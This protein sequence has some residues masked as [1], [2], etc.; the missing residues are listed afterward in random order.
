MWSAY[1]KKVLLVTGG[2]GFLGTTLLYRSLTEASP[3]QVYVLCR[4]GRKR[5]LERWLEHLPMTIFRP[6]FQAANSI[7]VLDGDITRPRMG[8]SESEWKK[9]E[10]SVHIVVHAASSINLLSRLPAMS[11]SIVIPTVSLAELALDFVNLERFVYISTAYSNSHLWK[12]QAPAADVVVRERIHPL[13]GDTE[14][15]AQSALKAWEEIQARASSTEYE[16]QDLFP[17]A[18]GYAKHLTERLLVH[19]FS[20]AGASDKLLIIRPS[21]MGPA[22]KFPFPGFCVP[23][24]TPFITVTAMII[25]DRG[26]E[27]VFNSR[28]KDPYHE[29]TLDEVPI[30]VVADRLWA[31]L[32]LGTTEFV[33]AVS[34]KAHRWHCKDWWSVTMKERVLPWKPGMV[35]EDLDWQSPRL[36][37][38]ARLGGVIG[39]SFDF[40]E[41]KTRLLAELL[42]TQDHQ[43]RLFTKPRAFSFGA[44]RDYM[45]ALVRAESERKAPSKLRANL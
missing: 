15:W 40:V 1:D 41:D 14:D 6:V 4:G 2:T 21:I 11:K 12:P 38:A 29:A 25:P 24:S 32:A 13:G 27:I 42:N 45:R 31:H 22:C 44:A 18:Y 19:H 36:H 23:S 7:A 26:R 37:P 20:E 39:T 17:W 43:L 3:A 8:L 28:L 34:G 30:D 9:L 35:F 33:H 5:A 10:E 16:S